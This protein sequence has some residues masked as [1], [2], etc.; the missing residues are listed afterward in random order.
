M[1]NL[2]YGLSPLFRVPLVDL[3]Y[4]WGKFTEAYH[5]WHG[6]EDNT[7]EVYAY[8]LMAYSPKAHTLGNAEARAKINAVAAGALVALLE[9]FCV[10]YDATATIDGARPADWYML[11]RTRFDWRVQVKIE[12][13]PKGE[14]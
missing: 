13:L 8:R 12:H 5:G 2:L 1:L 10:A 4:T 6:A 11:E 7:V 14:S 9:E 3:L